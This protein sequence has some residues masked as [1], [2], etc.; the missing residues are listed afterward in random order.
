MINRFA[1][2]V[3]LNQ[4][5]PNLLLLIAFHKLPFIRFPSILNLP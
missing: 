5:I 1:V 4:E 3:I 2:G